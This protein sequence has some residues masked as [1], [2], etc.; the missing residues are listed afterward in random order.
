M[1]FH[2]ADHHVFAAAVTADGFAEHGESLA[3]AGSVAKKKLKGPARF[4]RWRRYCQPLIRILGHLCF[5]SLCPPSDAIE[6]RD[7][8]FR[9]APHH[10]EPAGPA[11]RCRNH[12][13]FSRNTTP[14]EPDYR[15]PL[16]SIG[17]FSSF[18]G[19]GHD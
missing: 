1:R 7:D 17:N 19:V 16:V 13:V 12:R 18:R 10:T 5:L 9:P 14:R 2:D 6:S 11:D 15:G 3:D 8:S 4:F